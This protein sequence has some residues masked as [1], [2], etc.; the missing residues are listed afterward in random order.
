MNISCKPTQ[1]KAKDYVYIEQKLLKIG[2]RAHLPPNVVG[3]FIIS[4][5]VG[6]ASFKVRQCDAIRESPSPVHAERMKVAPFGSLEQFRTEEPVFGSD[7]CEAMDAAANELTVT[8]DGHT[9]LAVQTATETVDVEQ[10]SEDGI[11]VKMTLVEDAT[12]T[13]TGQG[14]DVEIESPIEDDDKGQTGKICQFERLLRV[15]I[16]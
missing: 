6:I 9:R 13:T 1:L 16:V 4:E 8:R 5:N 10:L 2:E 15:R 7:A 11:D 14:H 12:Q 3:P